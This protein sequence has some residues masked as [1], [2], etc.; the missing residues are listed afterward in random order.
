MRD[1]LPVTVAVRPAHKYKA[2]GFQA[3]T[4]TLGTWTQHASSGSRR[5]ADR[6]YLRNRRTGGVP[7]VRSNS[8]TF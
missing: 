1:S 3:E 4:G 7:L 8:A 6:G 5:A 2:Q